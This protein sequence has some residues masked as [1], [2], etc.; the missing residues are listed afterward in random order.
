M[1]DVF[2]SNIDQCVTS[3]HHRRL[4]HPKVI[5]QNHIKVLKIVEYDRRQIDKCEEKE[6]SIL[7]LCHR[8]RITVT[9]WLCTK[10]RELN[11]LAIFN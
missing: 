3:M 7:R 10:S 2:Q 1:S 9:L 5:N 4:L 11:L 8:R 6:V